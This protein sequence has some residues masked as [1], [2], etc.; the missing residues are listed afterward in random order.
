MI[1]PILHAY[2]GSKWREDVEACEV[3]GLGLVPTV[4]VQANAAIMKLSEGRQGDQ[5]ISLG[6]GVE[7]LLTQPGR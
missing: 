6:V 1:S 3:G 7:K 5:K 4:G 2:P